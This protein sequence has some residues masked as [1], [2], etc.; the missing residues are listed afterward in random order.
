MNF[1]NWMKKNYL[2]EDSPKGD[3]AQDIR[4]DENFPKNG[5]GKYDGWGRL[6]RNYLENRGACDGCLGAFDECWKEYVSCAKR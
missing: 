1:K 2:N 4:T 6:L 5:P 3:L